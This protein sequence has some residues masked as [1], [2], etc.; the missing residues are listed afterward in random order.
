MPISGVATPATRL[1]AEQHEAHQEV[2]RAE[3][4]TALAR[5]GALLQHGLGQHEDRRRAQADEQ[6]GAANTAKRV[7]TAKHTSPAAA[8]TRP[9]A[10]ITWRGCARPRVFTHQMP[11]ALPTPTAAMSAVS[12][13]VPASAPAA[14]SM[15]W[16]PATCRN[17]P[18]AHT[19]PSA[20]SASTSTGVER[21]SRQ[22]STTSCR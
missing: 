11:K 7:E 21:T 13:S 15:C 17:P 9:T 16:V 19:A 18:P 4:A 12:R 10:R 5:L 22:P 2:A 20:V 3:D 1:P 6:R 14:R 8:S